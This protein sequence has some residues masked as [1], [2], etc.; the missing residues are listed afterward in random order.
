MVIGSHNSWSYLKA[1]KWYKR[2]F[3]WMARC[4]RMD[5]RMQYELGVRCFDLRL[6]TNNDGEL[7]IAHGL[8]EYKY[9]TAQLSEDLKWLD[10]KGDC[11]VRVMHEARMK[12]QYTETSYGH[13][14]WFCGVL[15]NQFKNIRFWGG[16]NFYNLEVD[17]DFEAF[18]NADGTNPEPTCEERHASVSRPRL[19]DDWWPWLYAWVHN[20]AIKITGTYKYILMIDFIDL[21]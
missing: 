9:T 21:P 8:M 15:V 19:I 20:E 1:A 3:A 10:G 17:Y 7:Y 6:R 11:Y 14:K 2:P 5:I 13:F 18:Y 4:Q 16:R 12:W